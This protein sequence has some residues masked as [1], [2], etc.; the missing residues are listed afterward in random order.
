MIGLHVARGNS[1]PSQ[2]A[3]TKALKIRDHLKPAV[4]LEIQTSLRSLFRWRG[5]KP[6]RS[7]RTIFTRLS[8]SS[9]KTSIWRVAGSIISGRTSFRRWSKFRRLQRF[10]SFLLLTSS[11]GWIDDRSR[12]AIFIFDVSCLS[13]AALHEWRCT[14]VSVSNPT[15][16]TNVR[17]SCYQQNSH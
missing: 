7:G 16:S 5:L 10:L 8:S 14:H 12:K 13:N 1:R 17:H 2:M 9:W 11:K 3:L 15:V 6:I 4:H